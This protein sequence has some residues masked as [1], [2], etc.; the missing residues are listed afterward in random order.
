[1]S[2]GLASRD[3][4]VESLLAE[5]TDDFMDRLGRG[6]RPQVEEYAARYPALAGV[7]RQVLPALQALR[8]LPP[9][10]AAGEPAAAGPR[11]GCLGD[12]R[13]LRE[14]GRGGMGV[15]YEA[16]QISLGRRVALKVLPFASTLDA[17]QLQRFKNEAQAAAQLHHPNIVPVHATGCERG[18]HYYAMQYIDG[19]TL[20]ALVQE[21]SGRPAA[22]PDPTIP[23][24]PEV[25]AGEAPTQPA[26]GP[27]TER[28][29]TAAGH[30][31]T[32]AS[33][34]IQA[35][36]ALEQAH[37]L[38]VVHRDVKPANLL[39]DERGRLWVTDFGLAHC[40]S[41]AGLTMTGDLV[42][43]LRYMSPEQ[44]LAHR[45]TVDHRTDVY[46]LGATLYE[47]L[48][49]APAFA[50][51]D[52]QELMRQI[53][54]EE[55][56]PAR[57]LNP[58]VPPELET[59]VLKAMAKEPADRYATAQELADDLRRFLEDRP[60]RARRPT[61]VQR[62]RSWGRRHRP[63]VWSV[64]VSG[65]VLVL[66]AFAALA[67]SY[68]YVAAEKNEK[69]HALEQARASAAA[70]EQQRQLAE[71]NLDL[72]R[73]A[74]DE[75]YAQWANEAAFVP[76]MEPE[77]RKVVQK[78]VVFYQEF[79][80]QRGSD[81]RIRNGTGQ[82]YLNIAAIQLGARQ[83]REA[84]EAL[85]EALRLFGEL[86]A[87][88]P[89][90]P[91]YQEALAMAHFL[92]GQVSAEEGQS[93]PAEPSYRRAI[94]LLTRLATAFPAERRYRASLVLVDY[95]LAAVVTRPEEARA[96]AN[97]T[98]SEAERLVTEA[99]EEPGYRFL[100]A[101]AWQRLGYVHYV[102]R[103]YQEAETACR[104]VLALW[105]N[106]GFRLREDLVIIAATYLQLALVLRATGR[107]G[108]AAAASRQAIARYE[109]LAVAF[110]HS[111]AY[112]TALFQCYDELAAV[113]EA[114]GGSEELT[115]LQHTALDAFAELAA[116]IP[117]D[118]TYHEAVGSAARGLAPVLKDRGP[119][120]GKEDL[121]RRALAVTRQLAARFPGQSAYAFRV[122][123]WRGNLGEV[124]WA[125]GRTPEAQEAFRQ[126]AADYRVFLDLEP[127]GVKALNNLA[128]LLATCPAPGLRD[129]RQ[130]LA[131]ARRAVAL[132]P[133]DGYLSNTLGIACY[134][135][136][137]LPAAIAAL[138]QS[139]ARYSGRP[140]E[141]RSESF[142]TFF[143]AMARWRQG[144]KNA[145]R[146]HYDRAVRWMEKYRPND[147]ELRRFRAEAAALLGS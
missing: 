110:R 37:Q 68:A 96:L 143:L 30:F 138:E 2:D 31:R 83:Y 24:A 64:A 131:L 62:L 20:A 59:I 91:K 117:D 41:Q 99:P 78:A 87:E 116:G 114:T 82:A 36:E 13:L 142:D 69:E 8:S 92:R 101:R 127:N 44:A 58:A 7:L 52:R 70:A 23:P 73:R 12:F 125:L 29:V 18:V 25:P 94:A 102:A 42:G 72:A 16:E 27:S 47:L 136:G 79:A 43:T 53:A 80:R 115:A 105:E 133:R 51:R 81:P 128:W 19:R 147:L 112:Y 75:I 97:A 45:G 122:A 111:R 120:A 14:V 9:E 130:A 21:L 88:D 63:V 66:L 61:L 118:P 119:V 22:G 33:L 137:D 107:A 40:Q 103:R 46:S 74:V 86:A 32:A 123:Y 65:A 3:L 84:G 134:R 108:E 54:F 140:D 39:V 4:S 56:R 100:L 135:A 90:A 1:M 55:P 35:A 132:R 124:L 113:L 104:K 48:T 11:G 38:G 106:P 95:Y 77:R 50:G 60:I 5:A 89:T 15:V 76:E 28:S 49:L 34:G 67:V 57:R 71:A 121:Y 10:S 98:V 93:S 126:A 6:E 141:E 145:A 26:R 129:G 146:A 17:R 109:K 85:A 144:D 139:M